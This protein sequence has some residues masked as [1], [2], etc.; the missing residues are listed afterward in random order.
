MGIRVLRWP[1]VYERVGYCRMHIARLE[2]AGKF[3]RRIRL[4]ERAVGWIEEEVDAWI[5]QRAR[6]RD[7]EAA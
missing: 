5:E 7:V 1:A 6:A 3:P 4:G 2:H